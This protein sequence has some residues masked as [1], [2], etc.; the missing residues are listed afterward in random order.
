VAGC[1]FWE[2]NCKIF[3]NKSLQ[4]IYISLERAEKRAP[5]IVN[6]PGILG[7]RLTCLFIIP[8]SPLCVPRPLAC[9]QCL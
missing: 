3:V 2:I 1:K 6:G 4:K 5:P 8:H 9:I 7:K